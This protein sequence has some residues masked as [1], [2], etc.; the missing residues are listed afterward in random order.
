MTSEKYKMPLQ[1]IKDFCVPFFICIALTSCAS[2][3]HVD[4][5][6]RNQFVTEF[7]AY[8]HNVDQ[9][10][11]ESHADEA[12]L[13][14]GLW[15]ALENAHGNRG[16]IFAGA[17]ISAMLGGAITSLMEGSNDGFEYQLDAIDGDRITVVVDH[18]PAAPGDC[19]RVRVSGNVDIY[20]ESTEQCEL[21]MFYD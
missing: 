16:D 1:Q 18:Y 7:Y 3:H 11:F 9:I 20:L 4:N 8:V 10:E 13:S 15:G 17:I 21:E 14:W 6:S 5:A 2:D 19:V 12:A